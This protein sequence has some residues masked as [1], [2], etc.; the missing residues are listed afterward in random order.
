MAEDLFINWLGEGS[1]VDLIFLDFSK[2]FDSVNY[3]L[4]LAKV[5]LYGIVPIVISWVECFLRRRKFQVNVNG[6]LS[7]GAEGISGAP[8]GPLKGRVL[9]VTYATTCQATCQ[10]TAS[11]VQMTSNSSPPV[12]AMKL[13]KA[14]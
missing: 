1:A 12:T 8:Q 11:F 3:W 13:S 7:Q 14:S 4:L 6:T 10:Q 2:A 5:L 9:F